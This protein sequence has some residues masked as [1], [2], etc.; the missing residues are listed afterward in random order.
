[1]SGLY[2]HIPFCKRL[3]AYCDFHF[4]VSTARSGEMLSSLMREMELRAE[5]GERLKNNGGRTLYFGGGTPT[6]YPVADIKRLS[7][8]ALS[9]FFDSVPDEWTIEANPDDLT[10]EYLAQLADIGVNRL[11]VGIQSFID[12]DLLMM[13][14][15]H[16]A[17]QGI[18]AIENA[19][20]AG[21]DNISLDLIYGLPG[22]DAD[23]WNCN[24]ETAVNIGVTHIAAYHLSIEHRT[25]LGKMAAK[26]QIAPVDE[27]ESVLQY[28]MLEEKL[29]KAG[30]VHY[31]V[32]NFA[33]QGF[34]SRHN[35]A[36]WE[37]HDY[38]GVGPSAHSYDGLSMRK[39]NAANNPKY[40]ESIGR[41]VVPEET[42]RLSEKDRYNEALIT[43]L[44]TARG[45]SP[46]RI[47]ESFAAEFRRKAEK[48]LASQMLV[49][50]ETYRIPTKHFLISDAIISDL[51]AD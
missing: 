40:I 50:E 20:K 36:Y 49:H 13:R 48:Y 5:R 38:I 10:S 18:E 34:F 45:L 1:M 44:R 51:I 2:I 22:A 46:E 4:S 8:K 25:I 29:A 12:R 43:A 31:E 42:E 21:F 32:S 23:G 27:E 7:D 19:R 24:L 16:S 39:N 30:F 37:G 6:I 15:R 41:G 14:R 11:S 47:P 17:R 35:S 3:C 26:G 28:E 9:L 33:L